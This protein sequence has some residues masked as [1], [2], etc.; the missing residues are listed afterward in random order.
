[1]RFIKSLP[2]RLLIALALGIFLGSI[3]SPNVIT[4]FDSIRHLTGQVV[5]FSVPLI[6]L[7]SVAPAIAKMGKNASRLLGLSLILAYG[8]VVLAGFL[9]M[10]LGRAILPVLNIADTAA[11]ARAMPAMIFTLN[12]PQIMPVMSALAL[13]LMGGLA[14]VWTKSKT[15]GNILEEFHNIVMALVRKVIIP[16]LPFFI[17]TTFANLA[18]QGRITVQLPVFIQIIGI[19]FAIHILWIVILYIIATLYSKRNPLEVIRYYGPPWLTAFGTMSSAATLPVALRAAERSPVL[20]KNAVSFG[21]PLFAHI[22]MPGSII[23]IV[24]LAMTVSKVLYGEL[25]SLE[26]MLVFIPL[27]AIFAVAAPGVPGGTL[28]ASLGLIYA[29]LGFDEVATGLMLAIFAIQDSLGTSCN[30]TSDGPMMMNL[31]K[32]V[33]KH[34]L[35][36]E[37]DG[38]IFESDSGAKE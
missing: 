21:I 30:I 5:M 18:F 9:S 13:A 36:P 22:H 26:T 14:V 7:G 25:P 33:G 16:I 24:M 17:G 27:L 34:G 4:V 31:S 1:M 10:F 2:F 20:D 37:S 19:L 28:M 32:Y 35:V 6:I 29:V 12:I 3:A 23:S 38:N 15:F 11:A 8:S